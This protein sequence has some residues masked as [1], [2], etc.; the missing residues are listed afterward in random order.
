[1]QPEE[2]G[3]F[4]GSDFGKGIGYVVNNPITRAVTMPLNYLQTGGRAI[5]LGLEELAEN[6][7]I[8]GDIADVVVDTKRTEADKRSNWEKVFSPSTTYGFG[9][10]AESTG[11]KNLDRL[12]GLAGDI[13]LDPLTYLTAGGTRLVA[14]LGHVDEAADA[15][16]LASQGLEAA[17]AAGD[18]AQISRATEA[19]RHAED[20]V[21]KAPTLEP[22]PLIRQQ[23]P[24]TRAERVE[25][26]SRLEGTEEGQ[27][28]L[29]EFPGELQRAGARGFHTA[30]PALKEALN[31]QRPGLR[32]RGL[33]KKIPIAGA[34]VPLSGPIGQGIATAGGAVR[35][36]VGRGIDRLP[37]RL[38]A[39]R[40]PAGLED[41]F[42]VLSREAEGDVFLAASE[43]A[44][45]NRIR[46]GTGAQRA[47]G[48]R[49]VVNMVRKGF[50]GKS[51]EAIQQLRRE[52]ETSP[53]S[54]I[55]NDIAKGILE[56]YENI[57]GRK[58]NRQY[59]RNE[60]TYFP[61]LLD[62]RW[63][64]A[65]AAASKRGDKGALDF[66][67]A[68]G[69]KQDEL[70]EEGAFYVDNMLEGSG[71]LEKS[72][73]LGLDKDGNPQTIKIANR[74]ITFEADD[75]DHINEK[76]HEA[77]PTWKGDFYDTD[78]TRVLEAYNTSLARQAGR[79]LARQQG[80]AA[81]N[82]L[83]RAVDADLVNTQRAINEAA[84]QQEA[85]PLLSTAQGKYDPTMPLP[86]VPDRPVVPGSAEDRAR[87]ATI[88]ESLDELSAARTPEEAAA[89]SEL[90]DAAPAPAQRFGDVDPNEFFSM[91]KS[92][93]G[94]KKATAERDAAVKR[95]T[96]YARAAASETREAED[97][98]RRGVSQ[99]R[100]E[101]VTPLRTK[102]AE[103]KAQIS[104]INTKIR[105]W[106]KQ[107][108]E[109]GPLTTDNFDELT[110][111]QSKVDEQIRNIETKIRR[112][113]GQFR[114]R[115]TKAQRKAEQDL[116]KSLDGLKKVRDDIQKN[117][118]EA[119]ARMQEEYTARLEA[120][121]RPV[122]EATE[123]LR[124]REAMVGAA[125]HGQAD[126]DAAQA[127]VDSKVKPIMDPAVAEAQTKVAAAKAKMRKALSLP[128]EGGRTKAPTPANIAE[129]QATVKKSAPWIKR[130]QGRVR[131]AREKIAAAR[132]VID[133]HK[134]TQRE[135]PVVGQTKTETPPV[136]AEVLEA[137]AEIAEQ[138]RLLQELL[139][140]E[141]AA[142]PAFEPETIA[143]VADLSIGDRVVVTGARGQRRG[144]RI[145]HISEG[146]AASGPQF[147]LSEPKVLL[148]RRSTI[149]NAD[150]TRGRVVRTGTKPGPAPPLSPAAQEIRDKIA[151]AGEIENK[152]RA[153]LRV[154]ERK[155]R[156]GKLPP[157]VTA[158]EA[159][160]REQQQLLTEIEA[161]LQ[162]LL[163]EVR[164]A[165]GIIT[166]ARQPNARLTPR[167]QKM[168]AEAEADIA[169][170]SP[171]V[172]KH[173]DLERRGLT[174][175]SAYDEAK[176]KLAQYDEQIPNMPRSRAERAQRARDRLAKDFAPGGKF[177]EEDRARNLLAEQKKF[178][179]RVAEL[180]KNER[181][182][183]A[184]AEAE[185][186]TRQEA[187]IW[188][189]TNKTA[190]HIVA[191]GRPASDLEQMGWH[192]RGGRQHE[193]IVGGEGF[194]PP[195][196][197]P[198]GEA[199]SQ[200]ERPAI[201][202]VVGGQVSPG[203]ETV[204]AP[205][206]V[207]RPRP[208]PT[209]R[210][211]VEAL[212]SLEG[213]MKYGSPAQQAL[214][215]PLM[216]AE[217]NLLDKA[218][219]AP[220][221]IVAEQARIAGVY[222]EMADK[223]VGGDV[224]KAATFTNL[225]NDLTDKSQLL[226]KRDA[227]MALRDRL[228]ATSPNY[229]KHDL[230][231]TI[232]EII[233]I[234][235][236][237]PDL[238][239]ETLAKVES[240]LHSHLEEL[241]R[242][243]ATRLRVSD[244]DR[245][246][247]DAERGR[248][249][250]V[251]VA[252]THDNW[253]LGHNGPM[254]EGDILVATELH[255]KMNNLFELSRQP[256][257]LGRTWNA[258][259]NLFKTYATLTPGFFVRNTIGGIFMNTADGVTLGAQA[260]G[261]K[262]WQTFIS[263]DTD[264]NWLDTQPRR[265]QEAFQAAHASGAGG[266]FEDT[267]IL[268]KTNSRAYNW[269]SSNPPTR[270][271]QRLGT[272]VEGAMRLGMALDS[273]DKGMDVAE[274]LGRISRVHFD[275]AQVSELDE[276][277]KRIIPFWTFMSRNLP[278][279]IQEQW[280]NPRV[281][282]YYDHLIT[283]FSEPDEEFTPDY[284]KRQGAWRT[285]ISIGGNPLYLQPDLGF[286]RVQSD[287]QMIGDTLSG[288]NAGALFSQANPLAGATLDYLNK[289]DSFYDRAYEDTDYKEMGGPLGSMLTLLAKPFGQVNEAG[290]VSENFVNYLSSLAPPLSQAMRL[291]PEASGAETSAD[292]WSK[293][294]RYLGAPTQLLTPAAQESEYWRQWREMQD[295]AA[296]QRGMLRE[297][298]L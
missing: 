281:Y 130:L 16:R 58:I 42:A 141:K 87:R 126:V 53:T 75:L 220:H 3:G 88:L 176:A 285:P 50:K 27:R 146:G 116:R 131:D 211:E 255:E 34:R 161:K 204:L 246:T 156:T 98:V 282:S 56:T 109:M 292:T 195:Y 239:D 85:A 250:K 114:G 247:A 119:P 248:L 168:I 145:D 11:H 278:L 167:A 268:H 37:G 184:R 68:T 63:R 6:V 190:R 39:L 191:P 13:A 67:E 232:D 2:E 199:W 162:P 38:P 22:R 241:Q 207:N 59:L 286:T 76:L 36:A 29:R 221:E 160:I 186:A 158:A 200:I 102:V 18:A 222:G 148:N 196:H 52:A 227:A 155:G 218:T 272:R 61:H 276:T 238:S 10:I 261:A 290:Q 78:P 252:T 81:G 157:A 203:G 229:R 28:I 117:V 46:L 244:L 256:R 151:A 280:T 296:R 1:M 237:N 97:A 110:L 149:S 80:A 259:T 49:R 154:T 274:S 89:A 228:N 140:A 159:T 236:A 215:I 214:R 166:P 242:I 134:A 106:Q 123:V 172:R 115:A 19:L 293:R 74:E 99:I 122:V 33:G 208:V 212:Q 82:P 283:N 72:R 174:T 150:A 249:G 260:E 294:A 44:A 26:I 60:D 288:E 54:N 12:I 287:I 118:R 104:K 94:S 51:D 79:D 225:A 233:S 264:P 170:Y 71:F 230:S 133:T 258:F 124:R 83:Y 267:G 152:Y 9:E 177:A 107:V 254:A 224:T 120:L 266:R 213:Q 194:E 202:D 57:T 153:S 271:G 103:T 143:D 5:T 217:Q 185:R 205:G 62:P 164:V 48:G 275:Y 35:T 169:Q 77:F 137:R 142:I 197:V 90:L 84:A 257:A 65:L 112:T 189:N 23:M 284:W 277:M 111:L 187:I 55:I 270:L 128:P 95:A 101:L 181:A 139:E 298:S 64:R 70:L 234:A 127:L 40:V 253:R 21:A 43:V 269:L 4:W 30:T 291:L 113:R 31:I 192:R 73:K 17:E 24:R 240:V 93:A 206:E 216:E 210:T 262:L 69:L 47:R 209:P 198:Q 173:E 273:F 136:P 297:A 182:A 178:D 14:G 41:A 20:L 163:E 235:Q 138:Q 108:P 86:D 179:D 144:I 125:P 25:F 121:D 295:E 289:R 132:E 265:V 7:P 92:N 91:S 147:K 223:A 251:M 231:K 105:K 66:I 15:L 175:T 96:T 135:T 201:T 226:A 8:L 165:E 171:T 279:Q 180:T 193:S 45:R 243:E 100:E 129:A 263:P 219:R 183:L 188:A 32:V 245:I